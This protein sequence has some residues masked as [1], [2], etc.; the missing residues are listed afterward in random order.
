[1][2]TSTGSANCLNTELSYTTRVL[3]YLQTIRLPNVGR[4]ANTYL[5][6][7]TTRYATLADYT[8]F[9]QG[10]PFWPHGNNI[11]GKIK[12]FTKCETYQML[13]DFTPTCDRHGAPHWNIGN[14]DHIGKGYRQFFLDDKNSFLFDAGA[15]Y[16]VSRDAIRFRSPAFYKDCFRYVR[17]DGNTIAWVDGEGAPNLTTPHNYGAIFERLWPVIFDARTISK[18]S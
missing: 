15:Q 2:K 5:W 8:V 7:I 12:A 4:E 16:I 1:M 10:N 13:D 17:P 6:H 11:I 3:I 18:I 14:S 9:I